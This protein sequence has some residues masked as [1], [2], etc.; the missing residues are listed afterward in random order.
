VVGDFDELVDELV[1][2]KVDVVKGDGDDEFL[3]EVGSLRVLG[4]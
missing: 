4:G 3:D 1:V 2:D